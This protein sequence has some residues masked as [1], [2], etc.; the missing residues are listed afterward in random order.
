MD[1]SSSSSTVSPTLRPERFCIGAHFNNST[2]L[3]SEAKSYFASNPAEE[4]VLSLP[5]IDLGILLSSYTRSMS[6]NPPRASTYSSQQI[7]AYLSHISFPK[8]KFTAL[9]FEAHRAEDGLTVLTELI[10]YQ[11]AAVPFEN[12]SLH[13]SQARTVS[14]DEDDLFQKIVESKSGR[15]G[16]CMENNHFFGTV[17]RSLGYEVISTGGRVMIGGDSRGW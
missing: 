15:G 5:S 8:S 12:L 9:T 10:K 14:L 6:F 1:A 3:Y 7:D 13:Y 16:Y 4:I 11:L 2:D 17:L